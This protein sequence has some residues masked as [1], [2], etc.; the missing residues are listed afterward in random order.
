MTKSQAILNRFVKGFIASAIPTIVTALAGITQ[1]NNSDE[2][3]AFLIGIAV[4]IITGALLAFEKAI[5]WVEPQQAEPLTNEQTETT[6]T[7]A[8]TAKSAKKK[9][10][11]RKT[12]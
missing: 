2:V 5:N 9:T 7:G 8:R 10:P 4:P 3:K 12:S 11:A 1:F 6:K